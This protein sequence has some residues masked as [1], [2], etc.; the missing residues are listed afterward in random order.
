MAVQTGAYEKVVAALESVRKVTDFHPKIAVT[1]GSGLG[2]YASQIDT[3]CEISY[4]EITGFPVSTVPGHEGKLIF[5]TIRGV[6]VVAQKGRVHFYEG[7]P[8]E[9]VIM[10]VRLLKM[11][12]AEILFL[13]N[14]AGGMGEGFQAGD[15][16]LITDHISIFV[17]NPLIGPGD[18]RFGP[19]FP[20]MS[21]VYDRA[22]SEKIRKTA[23]DNGIPLQEGVY[24]QLTGPVYETPTEVRLLR[25]LGACAVGMS[26][27]VEA[28]TARHMGMRVVGISCIT[29]LAAGISSVPLSHEE[30]QETAD[31][32]EP[33]FTR[34]MTESIRVL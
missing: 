4:G 6:P 29:N 25:S 33:V 26:T 32:T 7:Y 17:P 1:L 8:M 19:R 21:E 3:V 23:A 12:G 28:M 2:H 34:L 13:T 5:G 15:L 14:A 9:Q 11:L 16:M 10:P 27:A 30:V 31:K 20:D 18:E 24:C 22:L